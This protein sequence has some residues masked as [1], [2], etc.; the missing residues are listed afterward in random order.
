MLRFGAWTLVCVMVSMAVSYGVVRLVA[1]AASQPDAPPPGAVQEARALRR[2]SNDLV[3]LSTVFMERAKRGG[4]RPGEVEEWLERELRPTVNDLRQRMAASEFSSPLLPELLHA[5]DGLARALGNP[6]SP[7]TRRRAVADA[8]AV[9]QAVE[10]R[11]SQLG[12]GRLDEESVV[13][14]VGP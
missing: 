14:R 8:L 6:E 11:I 10:R 2:F 5:A 7:E 1:R 13:P 12:V 9:Q 3:T 4:R